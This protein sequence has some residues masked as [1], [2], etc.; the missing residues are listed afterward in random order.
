VWWLVVAWAATYETVG[1]WY[2]FDLPD[3]GE[4]G[5][6]LIIYGAMLVVVAV[7]VRNRLG[8]PWKELVPLR[9]VDPWLAIPIVL[10]A[11]GSWVVSSQLMSLCMALNVLPPEVFDLGGGSQSGAVDPGQPLGQSLVANALFPGIFEEVLMRGLVLQ[12]LLSMMSKRRAIAI[13]AL[14]FA[15]IHFR[16]ER[17]PDIL[18]DGVIW[19][20]MAVRTG[21]LLPSMLAHTLYDNVGVL[22][23]H[24]FL[25]EDL[26][27]GMDDY[28]L[29]P[30]AWVWVA[31]AVIVISLLWIRRATRPPRS[32]TVPAPIAS[33]YRVPGY[34]A[35]LFATAPAAR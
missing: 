2:A 17:M 24:G 7:Y 19:G 34:P 23:G 11:A 16:I 15:T 5:G 22:V 3:P 6:T 26:Q 32:E 12:A 4:I 21:S 14:L 30:A 18:L 31:L 10:L 33:R 29:L 13:S 8:D 20:W 35:R 28:G 27:A 25:V 1:L 9:R